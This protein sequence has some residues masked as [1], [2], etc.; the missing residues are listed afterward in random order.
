MRAMIVGKK[1]NRKDEQR[2]WKLIP[3][4]SVLKVGKAQEVEVMGCNGAE[5][6]MGGGERE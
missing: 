1:E 2:E 3:G 5:K 6:I 4:K